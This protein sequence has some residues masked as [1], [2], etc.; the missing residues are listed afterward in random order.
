MSITDLIEERTLKRGA[1]LHDEEDAP[2][3]HR[4]TVP[5]EWIHGQSRGVDVRFPDLP[6]NV[7]SQ[8]VAFV[9]LAI[10][11]GVRYDARMNTSP[12][13]LPKHRQRA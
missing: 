13:N 2:R 1:D 9:I 4:L 3:D 10:I 11:S 7:A 8:A 6:E 12:S 5:S